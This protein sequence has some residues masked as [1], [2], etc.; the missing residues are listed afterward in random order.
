[1]GSARGVILEVVLE[2][3]LEVT[4]EITIEVTSGAALPETKGGRDAAAPER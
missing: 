2:V 3:T 4:L 1:L